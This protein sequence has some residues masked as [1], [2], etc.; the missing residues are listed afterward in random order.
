MLVLVLV[1]VLVLCFHFAT[2]ETNFQNTYI[3]HSFIE[4]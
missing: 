2:Q 4:S 1:L 3:K